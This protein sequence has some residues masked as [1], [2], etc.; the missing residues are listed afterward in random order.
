MRRAKGLTIVEVLIAL[1]VIAVAFAALAYA[2]LTSLK[3]SSRSRLTSEAKTVAENVLEDRV[4]DVLKVDTSSTLASQ[5]NDGTSTHPKEFFFV[6]YYYG[7]P[8]V[9]TIQNPTGTRS[10]VNTGEIE[11]TGTTQRT[12]Q[13]GTVDATWTID[14]ES[15]PLGE[16]VIDISVTAKH[17]AGPSVTVSDRVSCYDVYPSPTIDTPAPCPVAEQSP[18]GGR[19]S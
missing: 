17:S 10:A 4:K 13:D 3:A 19:T 9:E 18:G 12:V 6:D 2:Q 7:C 1:A 16:G 8:T 15:G 14:G 11:C 5:F